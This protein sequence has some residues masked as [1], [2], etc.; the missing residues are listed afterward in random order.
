MPRGIPKNP[1]IKKH[2]F[3]VSGEVE[4][5]ENKGESPK[6]MKVNGIYPSVGQKLAV[7]ELGQIQIM[8]QMHFHAKYMKT[9]EGPPEITDAVIG[10]ITY[11]GSFTEEEFHKEGPTPDEKKAEEKP[12][13]KVVATP[14]AV[15]SEG[16]VVE[17]KTENPELVVAAPVV[18]PEAA[19]ASVAVAPVEPEPTKQ[20]LVEVTTQPVE[21][22]P[23]V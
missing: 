10:S 2:Y 20:P 6:Y 13:L 3:V 1:K 4:Y 7:H 16:A 9:H 11:L 17:H 12:E 15:T 18:A 23:T 19:P 21:A 14:D 22:P 8:L 5:I